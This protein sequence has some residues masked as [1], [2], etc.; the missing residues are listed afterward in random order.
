MKK[1]IISL[2][3]FAGTAGVLA[4]VQA[5]VKNRFTENANAEKLAVFSEILPGST[6]FTEEPYTGDDSNIVTT[7]KGETGYVVETCTDGYVHEISLYIGVDNDGKIVGMTTKQEF[8]TNGLG[9]RITADAEFLSQYLGTMGGAEVGSDIDGITG[10][11]VT[12]KAVTKAVN[13]A[14]AFVTGADVTSGATEWGN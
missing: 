3:V 4:G 13:S 9:E 6:E 10:A 7:Y 8:E 1:L 14:S 5:G 2:A 12:S 11:T